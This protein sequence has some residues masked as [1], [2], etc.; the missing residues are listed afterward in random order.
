MP[1]EATTAGRHGAGQTSG[2]IHDL[3]YRRY[4]GPRLGRRRIVA[5]LAWHSFRSAFGLGRGAKAKVVPV[6]AFLAL[7]LPAVVNAFA[8]SS[9]NARVVDYD[10]YTPVLRN[11]IMIVFVAVQAPELVSRD[12]RSRVLPLYFSRPIKTGDYPL[13]K[14]LGFTAAL[15]VML[16]VPLLLLYAGSIANV[17]GGSAVWAQTRALIPGLLV[18][19]MFAMVLAPIGLFLA[20]LTGRRAFATGAVAIFFLLTYTLAEI[21]LQVESQAA[22]HGGPPKGLGAGPLP[23]VP[24]GEKVAGLFSPFTLFDGVRMW[25]GGTNS[26]DNV[27]DPGG[28]GAAYALVLLI[29]FGLCL[30]GLAARYRKARLS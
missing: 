10:T 22:T 26:A 7:C 9:G 24:L 15:L 23:A 21:L 27:A 12:L 19:L 14:Y 30:Y 11:L 3:G 16:E 18:G 13:A 28:F 5:A 17:H 1:T 25:L 6:I 4:D 8:M 2:V 29:L 20:S